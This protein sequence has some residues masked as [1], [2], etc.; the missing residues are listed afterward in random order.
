MCLHFLNDFRSEKKGSF[1]E[2]ITLL[3]MI[4]PPLY[5][6]WKFISRRGRD[7]LHAKERELKLFLKS[8]LL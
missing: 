2:S 3:S 8:N 6:F 7:H 4:P 5:N 1:A